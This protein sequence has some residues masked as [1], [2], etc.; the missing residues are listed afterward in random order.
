V[1]KMPVYAREHVAGLWLV[2]PLARTLE[3]YR[4]D[5]GRWVVV[6]PDAGATRLEPFEE[7]EIDRGRWWVD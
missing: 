2:D 5:A 7:I 3:A 4:L 6:T 1:K